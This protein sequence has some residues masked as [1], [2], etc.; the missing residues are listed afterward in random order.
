MSHCVRIMLFRMQYPAMS[1]VK[2]SYLTWSKTKVEDWIW[3]D[4]GLS[5]KS[6]P[7]S[8]P[9]SRLNQLAIFNVK[10]IQV[11]CY[12]QFGEL[13]DWWLKLL[14]SVRRTESEES[15]FTKNSL[16][17][18]YA[19]NWATKIS[20]AALLLISHHHQYCIRNDE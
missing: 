2:F 13:K 12:G 17:I 10:I 5:P 7:K 16:T 14:S 15:E 1:E 11:Q 6:S 9:K 4:F 8:R 3:P 19:A 18:W 20:S